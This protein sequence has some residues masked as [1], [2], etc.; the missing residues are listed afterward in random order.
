MTLGL[1][2]ADTGAGFVR[3]LIG[4]L[5]FVAIAWV[6][7]SNRRAISW[8]VVIGGV[9]LQIALALLLLGVPITAQ[10]FEVFAMLVL[11]LCLDYCR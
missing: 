11:R 5:A 6:F 7:S 3:A 10:W 8:R 4:I 2:A 1:L 9:A